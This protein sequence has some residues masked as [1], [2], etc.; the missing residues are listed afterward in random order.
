MKPTSPTERLV[1]DVASV[2]FSAIGVASKRG[3]EVDD[4]GERPDYS[5]FFLEGRLGAALHRLNPTLP[6]DQCEQVVR[7][8]SRPP[9][10]TLIQNN[11]WFHDLLTDGVEV[12]Y[13]EAS[14]GETRGA[15]AKLIDFE[16]PSNNDL[17]IVRQFIAGGPSVKPIR[18][19]VVVFLNG[20]PISV[21]E[22]KDP[23]D[24]RA[25]LGVAID[26]LDRYM[27]V[28]PDLF[29]PNILLVASDGLLT[30]VG[31]ITS[32]HDRFMPWRS[33]EAGKP[34]LEALIRGLF[35]P[36]LL[37]D[38][39]RTCVTFEENERGRIAKK[40]AGYHQFR[41]I[42]RTRSSV[43][44]AMR[45]PMGDGDGRGGVVWHTQ[46]SG[47]SLTMLMLAGALIREPVM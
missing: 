16:S 3:V 26:Q 18:L 6:V 25:D 20:L 31:S 28:A 39:L 12:E 35:E 5:G 14:S 22:L 42:R 37:T 40:I 43:L 2:Y 46:G 4:A 23:A 30:R 9:H 44:A 29:V 1:E 8:V 21:I 32:G 19:D 7:T 33:V 13:R 38:Y 34:T 11:R 47:K 10:P 45:P 24:T 15:W 41:A 27:N 36:A 17:L